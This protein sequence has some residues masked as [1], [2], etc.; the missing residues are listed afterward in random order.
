MDSSFAAEQETTHR[1][2]RHDTT[3]FAP[4]PFQI[5]TYPITISPRPALGSPGPGPASGGLGTR[6][7]AHPA[8]GPCERRATARPRTPGAAALRPPSAAPATPLAP[9]MPP[10]R[11]W[12][13]RAWSGVAKGSPGKAR[14]AHGRGCSW[15]AQDCSPLQ[16]LGSRKS[17]IPAPRGDACVPSAHSLPSSSPGGR[18]L[19]RGRAGLGGGSPA[20]P[21]PEPRRAPFPHPP[22]LCPLSTS[23]F[24]RTLTSGKARGSPL[25]Q[26]EAT[27]HNPVT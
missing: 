11:L 14:A 27:F 1:A 13:P 8:Q 26:P 16:I 21:L 10:W 25:P 6:R 2:Q 17:Q 24:P 4:L 15:G 22:S 19:R 12:E 9:H 18:A 7:L 5:K 3:E 20:S 23:H